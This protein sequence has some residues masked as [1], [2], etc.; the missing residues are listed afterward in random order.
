MGTKWNPKQNI[1]QGLG[2]HGAFKKRLV[3]PS[4]NSATFSPKRF[5]ENK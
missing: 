5:F 1:L 3:L 4:E 2:V